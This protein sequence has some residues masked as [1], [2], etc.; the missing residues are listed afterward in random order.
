MKKELNSKSKRKWIIGG[1]AAFTSI[2]LLTTG[3]AVWVVGVNT[4]STE[5][6][7]GVT[8]DTAENKSIVFTMTISDTASIQLREAVV[9]QGKIVNVTQDDTVTN[10]LTISY[11]DL[12]I[13]YG[14]NAGF[15]FN[16][17]Q[18]S[19]AEPGATDSDFVSVK[20][21]SGANK[22][23]G[24]YARSGDSFTYLEAPSPIALSSLTKDES[25]STITTYSSSSGS[26]EFKWGSFFD[27]KSPAT[28][29]NEKYKEENDNAKLATASGEIT[30]ELEQMKTQLNDKKIKLVATLSTEEVT[31]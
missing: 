11:T 9:S 12:K 2:S 23:T 27:N 17:I 21:A 28:F 22:L 16:S 31:A 1:L 4:T 6:K 29:Y 26:L 24:G 14:A 25:Q 8:V 13:I 20:T 15:N 19:I 18:F 5:N 7:I 10:P 3:F 30:T